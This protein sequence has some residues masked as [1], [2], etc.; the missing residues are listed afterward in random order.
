MKGRRDGDMIIRR[1]IINRGL[2]RQPLSLREHTHI[3]D[4][5]KEE[6]SIIFSDK[7]NKDTNDFCCCL[8]YLLKKLP[9]NFEVKISNNGEVMYFLL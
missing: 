9:Y 7:T 1:L 8:E 2:G 3:K 5:K 6:N 4:K